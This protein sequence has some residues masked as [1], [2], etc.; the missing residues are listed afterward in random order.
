M[1]QNADST[2]MLPY[3]PPHSRRR[4]S[5]VANK[6]HSFTQ[7]SPRKVFRPHVGKGLLWHSI[8][9]WISMRPWTA[10]SLIQKRGN[11][12]IWNANGTIW[13]QPEGRSMPDGYRCVEVSAS[14]WNRFNRRITYNFALS[15]A[16]IFAQRALPALASLALCSGLIMRFDVPFALVSS[17]DSD[18]GVTLESSLLAL[19]FGPLAFL[20]TF[21][22]SILPSVPPLFLRPRFGV[23]TTPSDAPKDWSSFS[24]DSICCLIARARSS[25]CTVSVDKFN[26][27]LL[28]HAVTVSIKTRAPNSNQIRQTFYRLSVNFISVLDIHG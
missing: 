17:A 21:G 2:D 5:Q 4:T 9:G 18:A 11:P 20:A 3:C 10:I 25:C 15:W 24:N 22:V 8:L 1:S 16:L 12:R 19:R 7:L 23:M 6:P 27:Q 13:G 26:M 14:L 28:V